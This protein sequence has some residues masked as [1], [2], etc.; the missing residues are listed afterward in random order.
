M[1]L[2]LGVVITTD[3]QH[4]LQMIYLQKKD[5]AFLNATVTNELVLPWV[6]N[7]IGNRMEITQVIQNVKCQPV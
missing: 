5:D 2:K 6:D 7:F 4:Q 1:K 3:E